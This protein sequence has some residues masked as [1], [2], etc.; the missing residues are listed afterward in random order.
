M[1]QLHIFGWA[2][3]EAQRDY[4]PKSARGGEMATLVG[5]LLTALFFYAHQA[6]STG[7][8][9]PGF[10]ASEAFMLYA[11]ILLGMVGPVARM[12]TGSRNSA[13]LPEMFG[14][15]FWI[16]SSILLFFSFP[17]DFVQFGA[18]LPNFF[19][20]FVSWIT[21]DIARV[22]FAIGSVGGIVF[23]VV[24]AI[25]YLQVRNLLR[26]YLLR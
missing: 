23:T 25:M 3:K 13:R 12:V 24:S 19:R 1:T 18:V 5:I 9:T 4:I 20:F 15:M 26:Q 8:F 16:F 17:F 21:N 14:S 7:F 2:E 11:A 22:L 6:R 10:G